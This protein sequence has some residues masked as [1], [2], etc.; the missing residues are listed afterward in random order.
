MSSPNPRPKWRRGL[1]AAVAVVLL[2]VAGG[3][4]FVLLHAPGNVSHPDLSFT[5][6]STTRTTTPPAH[7][8]KRHHAAPD[9]FVWPWYGYDAARTRFFADDPSLHPPFHTK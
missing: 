5:F 9:R 8:P 3:V 1:V 6:P 7:H 2:V 4:A